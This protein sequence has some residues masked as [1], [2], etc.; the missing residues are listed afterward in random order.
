M[1]KETES[2]QEKKEEATERK[3]VVLINPRCG[4]VAIE[5]VSE[6]ELSVTFNL[7]YRFIVSNEY[8]GSVKSIE[9]LFLNLKF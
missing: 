7:R 8:G 6:S 4:H 5:E 1:V 3:K 9:D 2:K